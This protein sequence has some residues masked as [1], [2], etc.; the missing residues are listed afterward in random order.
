MSKETQ[1][2]F[3]N[4]IKDRMWWLEVG[5]KEKGY[6]EVTLDNWGNDSYTF[7]ATTDDEAVQKA[8]E[9]MSSYRK[10][11]NFKLEFRRV[12]HDSMPEVHAAF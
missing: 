7:R 11:Y 8:K 10:P 9:W 2:E 3:L 1:E 12:L 6:Y 4:A 5:A